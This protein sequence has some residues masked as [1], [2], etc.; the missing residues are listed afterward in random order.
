MIL[1]SNFFFACGVLPQKSGEGETNRIVCGDLRSDP[2]VLF[3]T[4]CCV[5]LKLGLR[6]AI[7]FFFFR[8]IDFQNL[9]LGEQ[10]KKPGNSLKII[11]GICLI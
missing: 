4:F 10:C 7:Q 8:F 1:A 5:A 3:Q 11:S 2:V 6:L 9:K